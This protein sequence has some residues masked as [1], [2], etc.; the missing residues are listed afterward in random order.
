MVGAAPWKEERMDEEMRADDC[1]EAH[2]I[3][4]EDAVHSTLRLY[5]IR[6]AWCTKACLE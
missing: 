3:G 5:S 6:E 1:Q 4:D 2:G